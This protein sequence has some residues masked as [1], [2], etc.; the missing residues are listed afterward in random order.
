MFFDSSLSLTLGTLAFYST[1]VT[2]FWFEA[3]CQYTPLLN[4]HSFIF[5]LTLFARLRCVTL[6]RICSIIAYGNITFDV[7]RIYLCMCGQL[8]TH[9]ADM[10]FRC[11]RGYNRLYCP[12]FRNHFS[13]HFFVPLLRCALPFSCSLCIDMFTIFL[14]VI[15]S[16]FVVGFLLF[17]R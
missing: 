11:W 16:L 15:S 10:I 17:C 2:L 5:C 6:T 8:T 1:R 7:R 3:P 12:S 9:T 14:H 4:L 13:S